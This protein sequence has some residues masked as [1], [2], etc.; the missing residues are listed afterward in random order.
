M[1][2]YKHPFPSA[3]ERSDIQE[4]ATRNTEL[5]LVMGDFSAPESDRYA[6]WPS[7]DV[8]GNRLLAYVKDKFPVKLVL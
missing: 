5:Y 3:E 4:T 8:F 2:I 6:R 7:I 1:Y